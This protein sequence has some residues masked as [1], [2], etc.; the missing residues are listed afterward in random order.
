MNSYLTNLFER[1]GVSPS[2]LKARVAFLLS[3]A[4]IVPGNHTDLSF[5][6]DTKAVLARIEDTENVGTR[7]NRFNYILSAIELVNPSPITKKAENF[8][9]KQ[10]AKYDE[11]KNQSKNDNRMTQKQIDTFDD[12]GNM[13][14]ILAT[15]FEELFD[16]YKIKNKKP[17]KADFERLSSISKKGDNW[18][19]F[20]NEYQELMIMACYVFQPALRDNWSHMH[21]A[22][23][24]TKTK[25]QSNNYFR[26]NRSWSE[27]VIHMNMFKNVSIMGKN[28][29]I[30]CTRPFVE[31]MRG[32]YQFL[33]LSNGEA[34]E[35][36]F[37]YDINMLAKSVIWIDS[38]NGLTQRIK[39]ASKNVFGK[40][41]NINAF[42]HIWEIHFHNDPQYKNNTIA[43]SEQLHRMLLH[44]YDTAKRYAL[45]ANHP[46]GPK[47]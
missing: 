4:K 46:K 7:F 9:R 11:L 21:F 31:L 41:L 22:S 2:T 35:Y 25:D 19:R 44:S 20:G 16:K 24:I 15:K 17:T 30:P 47:E 14:S 29:Q 5:L 6:N 28:V 40:D 39:R 3:C 32:W 38:K 26:F 37:L 27:C 18:Y 10:Y 33:L 8:Y 42:R 12:L 34:P 23:S 45:I 36:P 1:E 13:Q 43:E